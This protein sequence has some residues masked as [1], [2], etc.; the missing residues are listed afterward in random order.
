M[1]FFRLIAMRIKIAAAGS[2]L[3][4]AYVRDAAIF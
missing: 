1:I 3:R 4:W 2:A